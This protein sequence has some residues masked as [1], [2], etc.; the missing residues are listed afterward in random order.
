MRTTVLF[1]FV[2]AL[3]SPL[4]AQS[5]DDGVMLA[6]GQAVVGDIY[7]HESWTEYWEGTLKRTNGNIGTVTT[8]SNALIGA[9]GITSRLN[10][11]AVVPHVATDASQGVLHDMSGFQDLS[12]AVKF[13]LLEA[14]TGGVGTLR[15]FAVAS[16]GMPMTSYT[17]DF[18]PLSIGSG[19]KRLSARGTLGLDTPGGWFVNG[20]GAYTL[21]GDVTLDRPYYFTEDQLF[22]SDTVDM[23]NV[24][25]YTAGVGYARAGWMTAFSLLQQWT[26]GGGDIRRQ[27]APFV[28]NRMNFSRIGGM[29]MAPVPGVSAISLSFAYGYVVDGRNVGQSHTF[30]GGVIYRLPFGQRSVQ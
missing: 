21:R 30:S 12:V 20:S 14:K 23:P 10:V 17:P 5:V 15:G 28:S 29:V 25:D 2:A 8:R 26:L 1:V 22:F 11:L 4:Q 19:S 13:R 24:F 9:Y 7:T 6:K 27:D 18:Y 3:A 16:T